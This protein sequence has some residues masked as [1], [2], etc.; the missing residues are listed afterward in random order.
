MKL[1]VTGGAGF[2]GFHLCSKL[3]DKFD[4]IFIIDIASINPAEYP[5]NIKYFNVDVRD[6]KA[7]DGVIAKA[8]VVVHGAAAL[9]LWR[10]EDIFSTNVLGT[11][12]VLK[13]ARK[14]GI[15]RVVFI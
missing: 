13:A 12:N 11:K 14:N 3:A 6:F 4:E 8:D 5:G 10:K 7:L 9:P 1:A 2:L 15:K